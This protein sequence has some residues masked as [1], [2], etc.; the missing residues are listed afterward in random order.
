MSNSTELLTL[1]MAAGETK[2]LE[3]AGRY[4][5]VI[6]AAAAFDLYLSDANGGRTEYVKGALSGL[7]LQGAFG[8]IELYSPT[9]QTVLLLVTD[10]TGG[11][12]RQP[13]VVRVVDQG[14][15]KT[16]AA[17]Q[18]FGG[19]ISQAT[20]GKFGYVFLG[21][22]AGAL[23]VAVKRVVITSGVAGQVQ[24]G[25]ANPAGSVYTSAIKYPLPNKLF[26]GATSAQAE[27]AGSPAGT[28][29]PPT[30]GELDGWVP[31]GGLSMQAG[32]PIELP[33]TTPLVLPAGKMFVVATMVANRDLT[34]TWD[35]EEL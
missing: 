31:Y 29:Y 19:V 18:F 28:V 35:V 11:T 14:A 33:L 24:F 8:A 16:L 5:E 17:R 26:G 7:Y 10:G 20:A 32:V 6:D 21:V 2:R 1:P 34:A 27:V 12:R 3:R 13:G 25:I 22:T 23:R 15:E 9:A 4:I 30:A